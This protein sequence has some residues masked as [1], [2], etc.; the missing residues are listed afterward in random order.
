MSP[1]GNINRIGINAALVSTSRSYRSAG[2]SHYLFSLLQALREM[3]SEPDIAAYLGPGAIPSEIAATEHFSAHPAHF[4]TQRPTA[5]I[6][7]EQFALPRWARRD[8]ISLLHSGTHAIPFAWTGPS[9]LTLYDLS[10]MLFPEVFR[11]GN[12][13]YLTW[14]ARYSAQRADRIITISESTARDAVRLL[15]VRPERVVCSYPGTDARFM[16]MRDEKLLRQFRE[17]HGLPDEFILYLGTIEPRKN[18]IRLMDAY[19][20]VRG[21][22]GHT[23]PLVLAGGPGPG[24][25]LIE[26]RVQELGLSDSIRFGGY[27]AEEEKPLW[28][29]AA[30][31]FVYPSLYEGFGLPVLEALA[32]GT[33]VMTGNRSSL[34]E[35]VGDAGILVDPEDVEQIAEALS[36]G[37]D[38]DSLRERTLIEGPRQAS[39]FSWRRAAQEHLDVYRSVLN[40]R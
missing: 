3:N 24:H 36:R 20:R 35:V 22:N 10:F 31:F 9:V 38:D 1:L 2:I 11:R 19:A 12:R 39:Q 37:L 17:R 34:P 32:C 5:R 28:Y 30:R 7:W 33:P 13:T 8:G 15:G 29:N 21:S 18:L 27:V 26:R 23:Y 14:M 6:L 40:S 16:P 4:P 25:E